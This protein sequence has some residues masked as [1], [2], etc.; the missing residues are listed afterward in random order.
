[1]GIAGSNTAIGD[2]I[3][4][5]LKRLRERPANSRVLVLVTDGANNGGE[6]EPLLAATLAA[7]ENV[8]IHTIG[9]GAVPEEGGVLSRFGFNPGLDLDEPTLRAIA[10]QTGG[11]Y[12]RAASSEQLQAIGE[13]LDRLE[14]AVQQPTQARVAEA[15]YVWPLCAAL[16]ISLMMVAASLWS[17]QLQRLAWRREQRR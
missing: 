16:L 2:A 5:A 11:E 14:P 9:I 4:L 13:A 8:R 7:E 12:F 10:E 6:I 1:M 3:G 17:A 15:L